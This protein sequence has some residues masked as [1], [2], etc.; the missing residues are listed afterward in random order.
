[1]FICYIYICIYRSDAGTLINQRKF[2]LDI[3]TDAGLTGAKP[4]K[5]PLPKGSKLCTDTG[6]I[7]TDPE[8]YRRVVGRLLYLN[9]TRP[10]VSYVV[11]HLSQF[12]QQPKQPHWD[13][14]Q[15]MLRYLKGTYDHGLFYPSKT[16]LKLV[17]YTDADWGQMSSRPLTGFCVFLGSLLISWKTKKQKTVSKSSVEVEYRSMSATT[18]EL[19]WISY[20]LHF[21]FPEFWLRLAANL[22]VPVQLPVTLYCDNKV[23]QHIDANPIFHERTKHVNIDCHYTRDKVLEGFLQTGHICY[24]NQLADLMTKPLGETRHHFLTSRLGLL[25]NP[26]NPP[27]GG[28][29]VV[30]LSIYS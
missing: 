9:I 27:W 12:L 20:L 19:Q 3:L 13:A 5:F 23:A 2:I 10:D 7:L 6:D 21:Y 14:A 28:W 8:P 30:E 11:Q 18:S 1:M 29:G 17:G 24:E 26:P 25:A 15:H 4:A 22:H 16:N